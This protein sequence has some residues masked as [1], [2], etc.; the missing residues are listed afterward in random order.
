MACV[1]SF[2]FFFFNARDSFYLTK[3]N[4]NTLYRHLLLVRSPQPI[5]AVVFINDRLIKMPIEGMKC[6]FN[7]NTLHLEWTQ[8]I[9]TKAKLNGY[10]KKMW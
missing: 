8:E 9:M 3:L 10:K 2:L 5:D 6:T 7:N 1:C 4:V